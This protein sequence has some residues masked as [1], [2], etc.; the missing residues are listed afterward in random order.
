MFIVWEF[1][2]CYGRGRKD[3]GLGLCSMDNLSS[4]IGIRR[5]YRIQNAWFRELFAMKKG[6]GERIENIVGL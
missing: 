1:R 6:L 2:Q 5:V 4:L 3:L